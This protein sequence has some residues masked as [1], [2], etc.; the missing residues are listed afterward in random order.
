MAE[1]CTLL[2]LLPD[3]PQGEAQ[4]HTL[5]GVGSMAGV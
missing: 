2:G 1:I 4:K 5:A 3:A